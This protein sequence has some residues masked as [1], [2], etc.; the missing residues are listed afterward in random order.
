VASLGWVWNVPPGSTQLP[1]AIRIPEVS[2]LPQVHVWHSIFGSSNPED[3]AAVRK[4]F[5]F[6]QDCF[7]WNMTYLYFGRKCLGFMEV[8]RKLPCSCV[9]VYICMYG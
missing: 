4:Y 5:S 6:V 8:S 1:S 2:L 3:V 9:C 7:D